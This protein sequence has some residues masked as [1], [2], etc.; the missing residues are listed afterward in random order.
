MLRAFID[1]LFGDPKFEAP[2]E[3]YFD[4]DAVADLLPYRLFD[5]EKG[6]YY[7]DKAMGFIVEVEPLVATD[8]V[9]G[10][11]HSAIMSSMPTSA[12]FQIVNWSS[13]NIDGFLGRWGRS[14][15][16]GSDV[17][18]AMSA[19]R[20]DHLR[21]R[22][23]GIDH[24][25][26]AIPFNR[27]VIICG[28][29]EGDTGMSAQTQLLEYKRSVL[30]ALSLGRDETM[31]PET[32]IAFLQEVLHAEEWGNHGDALYTTQLPINA[33]IPGATI[34]VGQDHLELG[35]EP[36]VSL[37]AATVA[38]YP[39]EWNDA[40][41]YLLFGDP[42]KI[43]DR[44]HGPV[45]TSL[46]AF[47]IPSQKATGDIVTQRAKMEHSEKTGFAKFVTDFA[48]KKQE[49]AE[50]GEEL[51]GGERLF[52]TLFSV[53]AYVEGS[54][55]ETRAAGSELSKIFRRVGIS[56][57]QEKYLQL[58][59]YLSA[60]PL[61]M[62]EKHI[63]TFGKLQ[64]MRLLKGKALC[65]LAPISGE[66]K[67][68]SS[69]SGMLLLG[70]QG[71]VFNWNNFISEGNYNTAVVGKSG[72]GKSVF[73]QEMVASIYANG[74]RV[75]VIDDG[76]SFKTTCEILGGKHIAFDGSVDLRLNPFTML[77][78]DKMDS[79]E[80]AA[81]AIELVTR[82][83]GSMSA[84]GEQREG[85]VSGMEEQAIATAVRDVWSTKGRNGEI[86]D[87]YELL[88]SQSVEDERLVDVC[89][90]LKAFTRG[91]TYGQYFEGASN[92]TVESA[93]TVVELSDVKSQPVL[94]EVI[95][96][97]IMFLGTE[98]M[99]KTDRSVPVVIL[100]DEAWDMLK[101]D[102][103]AAF[104]EGVVRRARKYTGALITGTQSVDDY[105]ANPAAEVCLQNSDWLVMLAQKPE[106]I[107]RLERDAKLSIQPGFGA[108]LK[109]VTSVPGQFSEMAIKGPGGWAF[110]RLLLDPFSLAVFS[111]KG[112]TVE[113]L[114]RRKAA[115]MSTVD[116]LNDM[117]AKGEVS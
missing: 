71:Q 17:V 49:Y 21:G 15:V 52:Q 107:E 58:P 42:D 11:L 53:V 33:Q 7:T 115:G 109:S 98:L 105:Y 12:G 51:E 30:S 14:R 103:T 23:F 3:D 70:R 54:R 39:R 91:D 8:E 61:G 43:A 93:F 36:K 87:V 6:I 48:G 31:Q 82:V 75:L 1:D 64:R 94:E 26:K 66:W 90:R 86:T 96:Q 24:P 100:I 50:L 72:A 34:K 69:G 108:R 18:E 79:P 4:H 38:K 102:G 113:H 104:I 55:E 116:A 41:G 78:A 89:A 25:A 85:R 92:V 68:N 40:L 60:L 37:T 10:N 56:L 9:V 47:S 19:R 77:Q 16:A 35:G 81:E 111:S 57:R 83:I 106:T 44:P 80:Y 110:G 20:I 67:G 22:R 59:I 27:R 97:I 114:N 99:Y 88:L 101:G 46:A 63:K 62:T 76:Y 28:W 32:L 74:G 2:R 29:T 65:A 117:V 112:S 45:L 13:P 84:L 73:M 5:P 95:L